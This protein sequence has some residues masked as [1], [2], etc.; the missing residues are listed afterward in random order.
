MVLEYIRYRIA[1]DRR[2]QFEEAYRRAQAV[3]HESPHCLSYELAH[4]VEDPESYVLRIE[5][6]SLDGHERGFRGGPQFAEFLAA[7]R[8]F[9]PAIQEMRHYQRTDVSSAPGGVSR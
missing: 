8:Q 1:E 5:W 6:D 9:V 2:Q 4:G 7:I 3:L